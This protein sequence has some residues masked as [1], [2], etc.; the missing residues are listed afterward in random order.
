MTIHVNIG[1][2]KARLSELIAAALRGEEV[3]LDRA[4]VP[5]VRI[6]PVEDAAR[7][8]REAVAKRRIAAFGMFKDAYQ[9][10]D[11]SLEAL[12]ADR[13]DPDE[14]ERRKFGPDL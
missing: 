5:Q 1:D 11:L 2:A 12:K 4:G 13:G 6:V 9:G 8:A 7:A 14:R 3:V 10:Y